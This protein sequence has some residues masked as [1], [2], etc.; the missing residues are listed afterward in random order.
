MLA[1][2]G[3]QLVLRLGLAYLGEPG[4]DHD[5]A[6]DAL[7]AHLFH[8]ACAE[9]RRHRKDGYVDLARYVQD[10]LVG[11]PAQDLV[12][13][14]VDGIEFARVTAVDDVLHHRVA[15]LA[16]AVGGADDGYR[17]RIHDPVHGGDDLFLAGPEEFLLR[18]E[19]HGN[20]CIYRGGARGARQHGIEVDLPNLGEIAD[21]LGNVDDDVRKRLSIHGLG[22]SHAVEHFGGLDA[23]EHRAS[24][25][26]GGGRQPE[27]DVLEHFDQHAAQTESHQLAEAGVGDGPDDDFLS[28]AGH[29]LLNL[30]AFDARVRFVRSGTS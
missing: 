12:G 11:L 14:G 28:L 27:G 17:A 4:R 8:G 13:L 20:Q 23:V 15:D 5:R 22:P 9:P 21:Q 6:G 10:A 16:L 2:H 1:R 26:H 18:G 30:D 3:Q 19:I 7:P 24:V 29:H 25:L